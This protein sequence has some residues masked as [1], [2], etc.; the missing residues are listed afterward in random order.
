MKIRPVGAELS[1]ADGR[2]D[3]ETDRHKQADMTKLIVTLRNFAKAPIKKLL[4][5][6]ND[7]LWIIHR[8]WQLA[9]YKIRRTSKMWSEKA[10]VYCKH[11]PTVWVD[12]LRKITKTL[13]GQLS[14]RDSK[15][16]GTLDVTKGIL[17][18]KIKTGHVLQGHF[19]PSTC[20]DSGEDRGLG[21][22]WFTNQETH[23]L[24]N[25]SYTYN[26]CAQDCVSSAKT[27]KKIWTLGRKWCI[28]LHALSRS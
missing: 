2:T 10:T 22:I 9:G 14:S 19:S 25:E 20:G 24:Y 28:T 13:L 6:F 1:H 5:L 4:G 23:H 8:Q 7:A 26:N 27:G 11:Y 15:R 18:K 21:N 12:G 17:K 3:G 16:H